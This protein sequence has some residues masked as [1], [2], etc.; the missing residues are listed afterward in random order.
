M[1][2]KSSL[3]ILLFH[4]NLKFYFYILECIRHGEQSNSTYKWYQTAALC[5][6][7]GICKKDGSFTCKCKDPYHGP[8]CQYGPGNHYT[9]F[10]NKNIERL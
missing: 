1:I 8:Q 2:L 9:L 4:N 10:K 3:T 7:G 5:Q 6:N